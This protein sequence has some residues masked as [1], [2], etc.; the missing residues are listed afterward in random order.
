[1]PLAGQ[2]AQSGEP[3]EP[4]VI[5]AEAEADSRKGA[6]HAAVVAGQTY[7][8]ET[9]VG[10]QLLG[11]RPLQHD[12]LRPPA[13]CHHRGARL[14]EFA[15]ECHAQADVRPVS[16]VLQ[17]ERAAGVLQGVEPVRRSYP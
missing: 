5:A 17:Q 7:Q 1:M 10:G 4:A 6:D 16:A 3:Q 12:R 8:V 14:L 15:P 13:E 2:L 9:Q 11:V